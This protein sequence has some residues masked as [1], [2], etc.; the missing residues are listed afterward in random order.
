M[1]LL[2]SGLR[3][4]ISNTIFVGERSFNYTSTASTVDVRSFTLLPLPPSLHHHLRPYPLRLQLARRPRHQPL[5]ST[6]GCGLNQHHVS[7]LRSE[8]AAAA[9][10]PLPKGC[11]RRII[12]RRRNGEGRNTRGDPEHGRPIWCVTTYEPQRLLWFVFTLHLPIPLH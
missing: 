9:A 3:V 7:S 12:T 2:L 5:P 1:F 8:V 6:E 4:F 10:P 11:G